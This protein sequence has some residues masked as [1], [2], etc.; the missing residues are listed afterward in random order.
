MK[1]MKQVN[2]LGL[3][4]LIMGSIFTAPIPVRSEDTTQINTIENSDSTVEIE[5]HKDG[6]STGG[7]VYLS[8]VATCR[9]DAKYC[10]DISGIEIQTAPQPGKSLVISKGAI[11]K[12]LNVEWP[13]IPVAMEG[14]ESSKV[15]GQV[16]DIKVDEL[17]HRLQDYLNGRLESQ[18]TQRIRV[19]KVSIAGAGSVRPSQSKIV[20]EDIENAP[21]E[22][23]SWLVKNMIGSRL[24]QIKFVNPSDDGDNQIISAQATLQLERMVPVAAKTLPAGHVVDEKDLNIE[25]Y[26]IKRSMIDFVDSQDMVVGKRLR[27]VA[28]IGEPF[29]ARYLDAPLVVSRNQPVTMIMK[30]DGIE[31][32]AKAM[33]V[34]AGSKGQIV[35]VINVANKKHLRARVVDERTVEAVAF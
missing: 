26:A 5:L 22:Q 16:A 19:Q 23:F 18:R 31:I 21:L 25:W 32:T 35:D 11:L 12:I 6:V 34:E 28:T 14:V 3:L 33:A 8:D 9:G 4:V 1:T 27:T 30:N 24:M 7:H 15:I 13:G 29:N 2:S 10:R 20:F 17:K